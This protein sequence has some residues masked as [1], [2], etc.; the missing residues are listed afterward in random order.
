MAVIV[1]LPGAKYCPNGNKWEKCKAIFDIDE[2][3]F[4]PIACN[5]PFKQKHTK[6]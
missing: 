3:G 6:E 1:K 5:C 4:R 2:T